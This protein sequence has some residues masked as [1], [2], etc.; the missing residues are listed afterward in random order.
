MT[1]QGVPT[2]AV[3]R[4]DLITRQG[5]AISSQAYD[6]LD[7]FGLVSRQPRPLSWCSTSARHSPPRR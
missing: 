1:Q 4:G 5:E 6:V 7:Y 2:I 3:K